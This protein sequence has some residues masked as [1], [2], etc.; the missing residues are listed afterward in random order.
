MAEPAAVRASV[1]L[2]ERVALRV[3][4]AAAFLGLSETA[5]RD[6]LLARCPKFFA[7]RTPLIPLDLL[8]EFAADLA[9]EEAEGGQAAI[10]QLDR[11]RQGL[12]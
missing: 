8:R 3:A 2:P 4:E 7:G 12:G 10:G 1:P 6:H 11:L 5:F 9:K